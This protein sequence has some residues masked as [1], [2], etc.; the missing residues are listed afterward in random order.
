MLP[1]EMGGSSKTISDNFIGISSPKIV[2]VFLLN[3]VIETVFN[4]I[5]TYKVQKEN[6]LLS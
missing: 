4:K 2:I 5:S 3:K 6:N 1:K